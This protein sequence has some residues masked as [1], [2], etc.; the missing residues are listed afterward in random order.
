MTAMTIIWKR[1]EEATTAGMNEFQYGEPGD[2]GFAF[3]LAD[4]T[5]R[6]VEARLPKLFSVL[7]IHKGI[8]ILER[9]Y[10]GAGPDTL[11]DLRSVT[12][13][14]T[15]AAVGMAL[16]DGYIK[17]LDD[18]I[19]FY[20]PDH[21]FPTGE[22]VRSITVRELLTMTSGFYWRTGSKLGEA[23]VPRM[24]RCK[25]WLRFI[26]RLPVD[27]ASRGSFLYRSPDSH[28]LS[29]LISS[30]S[31]RKM[32]EY[33]DKKLFHPMSILP[34]EWE[35]DPQGHTA[36]H[37]HLKLNARDMAK[38]GWLYMSGGIWEGQ[39]LLPRRWTE[40]SLTPHSRGQEGFG[41]YGYQWWIGSVAGRRAGYAWGHGGNF[42][43]LFPSIETVIAGAS[44][45]KVNRWRDPRKL[46]E[47]VIFRNLPGE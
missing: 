37:I 29:C 27:P 12:K 8:V 44:D 31:G 16:A 46:L 15:S 40:D 18:P 11:F 32:S 21:V 9:Y 22:L 30:A 25:D 6:Y 2:Y 33:L 17:D 42:I 23:Y 3:D 45:P 38:F 43:M 39:E 14:F 28:L 7:M 47:E 34:G 41:E 1:L 26:L 19:R 13:S 4:R 20:L 24:H 35:E 36:G 10:H 5:D